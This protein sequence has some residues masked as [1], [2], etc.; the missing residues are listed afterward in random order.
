MLALSA[1][2][3][4]A[5]LCLVPGQAVRVLGIEL[6]ALGLLVW[7]TM[8]AIQRDIA[9]KLDAPHRRV[10]LP[11]IIVGQTAMLSFVAAGA[12]VIAGG[13]TGGIYFLVPACLLSYLTAISEPWVLLVEIHR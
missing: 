6:L 12:V 1:V 4:G 7:A 2:L 13:D 5:S 8:T 10:F 3:I 11:T 9:R